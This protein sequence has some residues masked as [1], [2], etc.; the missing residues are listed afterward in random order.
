[1]EYA[2]FILYLIAVIVIGFL[3]Y[4]AIDRPSKV[5]HIRNENHPASFETH[6][7]GYGWRPYWRKYNGLPGFKGVHK[8]QMPKPGKP[9]IIPN[10]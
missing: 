10:A 9:I 8:P 4:L 3:L 2:V 6:W 5:Q 1:M 7:W